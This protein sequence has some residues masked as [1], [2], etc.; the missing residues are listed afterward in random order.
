V[1]RA[2]FRL[3]TVTVGRPPYGFP[4]E[5]GG[6]VG[7]GAMAAC[8]PRRHHPPA[9]LEERHDDGVLSLSDYASL[10]LF[11]Y[12][13]LYG[14]LYEGAHIMR[15]F[16]THPQVAG[17]GELQ[18]AA[19]CEACPRA[20]GAANQKGRH[21]GCASTVRLYAIVPCAAIFSS[22]LG[23]K[24]RRATRRLRGSDRYSISLVPV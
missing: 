24:P 2:H 22:W 4:M 8:F 13:G 1:S 5:H 9:G 14:G 11:R 20:A 15:Y 12:R 7:S 3:Q 16:P 6:V 18:A 19:E 17:Q 23:S 21:A 10:L